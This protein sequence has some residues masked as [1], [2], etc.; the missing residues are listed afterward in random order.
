MGQSRI[1][2]WF[3]FLSV[4]MVYSFSIG[5]AISM[6]D[7]ILNLPNEVNGWM[8]EG[9][10]KHVTKENIFDYM[11]G[12]G[13]LYLSY[14]FD[15]LIVYEYKDKTGNEILVELYEMKG[16]NDAFGLLSM[17]W[18]GDGIIL[19]ETA[20]STTA[21]S[22]IS[23]DRALYGKGYIRIWSDNLYVRILAVRDT[24]AAKDV[25]LKLGQI[26]TKDRPDSFPP[27]LIKSLPIVTDLDWRL[28]HR[29]MTYFHSHL[30]LNSVY[31]ISHEN[32]LNFNLST[33]AV[34]ARYERKAEQKN[35]N[36]LQLLFIKYPGKREAGS[37]LRNFLMSYLPDMADRVREGGS[38][39]GSQFV[40]IED[41]WMGYKQ[42]NEFLALV[43]QCPD[44][45]SVRA[46]IDAV[47]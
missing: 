41:G 44:K 7:N 15:R 5:D 47:F 27:D 25:I 12:S 19:K 30:V 36:R 34:L 22:L 33:E 8:R 6:K 11:N 2:K 10:M 46:I 38:E 9:E 45:T 18:G 35:Q 37:A 21:P 17:D 43:F 20:Q 24:P 1:G 26:I 16:S 39:T 3:F 31:Y 14:H 42:H 29:K 4:L 40:K 23:F 28:N 32:I 13:E